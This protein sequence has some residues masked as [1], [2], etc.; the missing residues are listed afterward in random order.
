MNAKLYTL[1]FVLFCGPV[2]AAPPQLG[3]VDVRVTNDATEPVPVTVSKPVRFQNERLMTI[4]P[5]T[6]GNA[7]SLFE[8][9]VGKTAI[10]KF[11]SGRTFSPV[12]SWVSCSVV[13]MVD[14]T[15]P[16]GNGGSHA[17][18]VQK[19]LRPPNLAGQAADYSHEFSQEMEFYVEGGRRAGF[20]CTMIPAPVNPGAIVRLD[21]TGVVVDAP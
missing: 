6:T 21:M 1:A 14:D 19:R 5:N 17:V 13:R 9:P 16:I 3:P 15:T 4:A 10:V 8:V 11:V 18:L 20:T 2:Y 7:V 12:D